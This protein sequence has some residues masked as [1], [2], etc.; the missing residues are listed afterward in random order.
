MGLPKVIGPLKGVYKGDMGVHRVEGLPFWRVPIISSILKK[1]RS[2]AADGG[3]AGVRAYLFFAVGAG[4]KAFLGRMRD[5]F[6]P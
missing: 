1:S 2:G 6:A 4:W 3:R 5:L